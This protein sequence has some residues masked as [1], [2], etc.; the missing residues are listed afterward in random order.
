MK[1]TKINR[2]QLRHDPSRTADFDG[3]VR[4]QVLVSPADSEELDLTNVCFSAGARTRPHI[5]QDEQV[6]QIIEGEGIVATESE[7]R[8]VSAGEIIVIPKGVWHWHGATRLSPMC[9]LSIKKR[10]PTNWKVEEKNWAQ[11]YDE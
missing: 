5:H 9:H 3:E 6:L 4:F 1:I 11:G 10:G 2:T 8:I 7:R